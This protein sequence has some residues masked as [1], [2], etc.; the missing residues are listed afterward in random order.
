MR[1][2]LSRKGGRRTVLGVG[3]P[4]VWGCGGLGAGVWERR[5]VFAA[6]LEFQEE[7]VRL[8]RRMRRRV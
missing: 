7:Y 4:W 3:E 2:I 1:D 8:R 5:S 6:A